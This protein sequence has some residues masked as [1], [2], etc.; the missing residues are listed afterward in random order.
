MTK[1]L[2]V[3]TGPHG[4]PSIVLRDATREEV[5]FLRRAVFAS[6]MNDEFYIRKQDANPFFQGG[7]DNTEGYVYIEFLCPRPDADA[8]VAW[9]NDVYADTVR[10][11][12]EF[13]MLDDERMNP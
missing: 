6:N 4:Q 7:S 12:R 5:A 2:R 8:Y 1:R 10:E 9:L 13:G 3:T 11:L